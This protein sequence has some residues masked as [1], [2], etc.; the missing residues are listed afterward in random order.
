MRAK[1]N[2]INKW[3]DVLITDDWGSVIKLDKRESIIT[4]QHSDIEY[5]FGNP[6]TL[7]Y[8]S[9]GMMLNDIK[10]LNKKRQ[11]KKLSSWEEGWLMWA[12]EK[13]DKY[14]S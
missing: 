13:L 5:H 9:L 10:N 2:S 4:I 11:T 14:R 6:V 1:I 7:K 12:E 3:G 8:Y